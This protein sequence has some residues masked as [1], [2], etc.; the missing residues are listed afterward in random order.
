MMAR[1]SALCALFVCLSTASVA[2][3]AGAVTPLRSAGKPERA[4]RLELWRDRVLD[5]APRLGVTLRA[6]EQGLMVRQVR[7]MSLAARIG[8]ERGDVIRA[9]FG[10]RLASPRDLRRALGQRRRGDLFSLD[11]QRASGDRRSLEG[12]LGRRSIQLLARKLGRFELAVVLV[13]FPDRPHNPRFRPERFAR[14]LFSRGVYTGRSP[15]GERVFGSMADYYHENSSGRFELTGRVYDW[16]EIGATRAQVDQLPPLPLLGQ[17]RLCRDA[18]ERVVARAGR[19]VFADADAVAFVAAGPTGTW[20]RVLW[21]HSSNLV[22]RGRLMPYYLMDEGG[23]RFAPIGVHCHEFGHVLGLLDKY[24]LASRSGLGCF[25]AMAVGHR[26]GARGRLPLEAPRPSR[27]EAAKDL[28][29]KRLEALREQLGALWPGAPRGFC[30][31]PFDGAEANQRPLHLCAECKERLGWIDPVVLEPTWRGRVSL[32]P[33]EGR[34]DTVAKIP[35]GG[36]GREYYLLE[37]RARS[38]F[39]AG[40][41][42]SGLLIWHVGSPD[43]SLKNFV[44]LRRVELEPAHGVESLD[45]AYRAPELVPFPRGGKRDFTPR[46]RP[47]SKSLRAGAREVW[48]RDI[49]ERSGQIRVTLGRP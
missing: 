36:S 26:G 16:V 7:P 34:P 17:A 31:A 9:A 32:E 33:V 46:T 30:R 10:E 14:A 11:V 47:S 40:L 45:S 6:A 15:S 22:W 29:S 4:N 28:L 48:L 1:S 38:G 27:M 35:L 8:L 43:A 39:N 21:P 24:G 44:P 12:R 2:A 23:E 18:M 25:C 13:E 42:S 5:R 19:D 3:Q 41:P 49:E 20:G 37:Y